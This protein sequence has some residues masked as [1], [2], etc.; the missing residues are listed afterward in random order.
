MRVALIGDSHSTAL[1]PRLAPMLQSAGHQVVLNRAQSGWDARKFYG[2]GQLAQQLLQAAPD[3][4]IVELGGNNADFNTASY[5]ASIGWLVQAARDAGAKTVLWFGPAKADPALDPGTASRHDRTA[6][7]QAD[8]LPSVGVKWF[9]SRPSTQ[10]HHRSD[11][12]H[13]DST[14]YDNW[15]RDIFDTFRAHGVGLPPVVWVG[16]IGTAGV[17]LALLYRVFR[18]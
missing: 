18:K 10:T 5:R 7:L 6:A 1:W 14:G 13:F 9:D 12:V 16:A 2:E 8:Y 11:G 4:V 17:L 3:T 15:S